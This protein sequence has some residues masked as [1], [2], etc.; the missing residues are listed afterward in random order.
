VDG[1]TEPPVVDKEVCCGQ[2]T[3]TSLPAPSVFL[4]T[5]ITAFY[6]KHGR[7]MH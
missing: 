2:T 6:V 5:H 3:P 4:C 1:S 7:D